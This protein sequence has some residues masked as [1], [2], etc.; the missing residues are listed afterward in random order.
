MV[1]FTEVESCLESRNCRKRSEL[2]KK[3]VALTEKNGYQIIQTNGQ[4][5]YAP[6]ASKNCPS[7]SK[8]CEVFI[9]KLHKNL[10]ED[11]LIPLFEKVGP[12]YKFRLMLD[13]MEQTR[14]YAFATYFTPQ[15]ASRAVEKLNKFEIRPKLKIVVYKSVDNRRLFIGNLPTD[16]TRLEVQELLK[17][18]VNGVVDVIMYPDYHQPWLN[19][20]FVFVEFEEHRY[21]ALAR[22]QFTPENLVAWGQTLYVDWADPIPEVEPHVMARVT[23]LYLKNLPLDYN[24]EEI[25][26]IICN[27][28]GSQVVRKVHKMFSY[29]F[30]HLVN[31]KHA[32]LALSKLQG[33][34][35]RDQAIEIEWARPRRYSKKFRLSKTPD[36]FCT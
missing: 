4:R 35:I 32:E 17:R 18:Y 30:V 10:Y 33:L 24:S 25:H 5:V 21:A 19:R 8:G 34:I 3:L 22:R 36:N 9:G 29:A 1:V 16:R 7:P 26:T 31:R 11:E 14:G 12:L 23:I 13:F 28:I 15:D 27:V 20:G 6:P 2:A